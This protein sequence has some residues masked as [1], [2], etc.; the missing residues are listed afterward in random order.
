MKG[1]NLMLSPPAVLISFV[2]TADSLWNS[3]DSQK[4]SE[5]LYVYF[6]I[7]AMANN[8]A[9]QILRE[10]VQKCQRSK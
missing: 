4:Y 6:Y 8:S 2:S 1:G 10:V 9:T 7:V 3:L 5:S